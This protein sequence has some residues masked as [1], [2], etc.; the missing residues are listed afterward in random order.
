MVPFYKKELV[1]NI[2]LLVRKFSLF[3]FGVITNVF[4]LRS[5]ILLRKNS[6][7]RPIISLKLWAEEYCA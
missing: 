7:Y 3:T 2:C 6:V 5:M 4:G 1:C